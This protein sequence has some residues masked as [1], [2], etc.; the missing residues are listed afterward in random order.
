MEEYISKFALVVEIE[1]LHN[2]CIKMAKIED[3]GYW[4]AKVE[5]YRNVLELLS[6]TLEVKDMDLMI[7][8]V[9]AG[10][11]DWLCMHTNLSHD[12]IEDCRNLMLTIKE[13]QFNTQNGE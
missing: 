3:S 12:K 2:E 9:I 7:H 6:G 5:A 11:C 8:T 4:Y 1:K 10:C 13:D